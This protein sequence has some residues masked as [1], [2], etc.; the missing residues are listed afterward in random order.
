MTAYASLLCAIEASNA[1]MPLPYEVRVRFLNNIAETTGLLAGDAEV[2]RICSMLKLLRP[3]MFEGIGSLMEEDTTEHNAV[4]EDDHMDDGKAS[5]VCVINEELT[6]A[7]RAAEA[8]H[9]KRSRPEEHW[10]SICTTCPD[11]TS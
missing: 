3:S 6:A 2:L 5:P 8:S 10:R 7:R 9:R 4:E 1:T 11:R